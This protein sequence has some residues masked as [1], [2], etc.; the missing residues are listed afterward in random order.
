MKP[1]YFFAVLTAASTVS[2]C[3][4]E[5]RSV[6]F[7]RNNDAERIA[8]I[9]KCELTDAAHLEANCTNALR[10]NEELQM[11][12]ELEAAEELFGSNADS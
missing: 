6:E 4:D 7:Y 5:N 3:K 9:E 10:A 2:A 11:D 1:R 12:Q 8:M